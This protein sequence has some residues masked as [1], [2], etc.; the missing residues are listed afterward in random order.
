MIISDLNYLENTSE[1]V[2]GGATFTANKNVNIVVNVNEKIN[3]TK[4]ITSYV[5][6]TGNVA[7]AES[8]ATAFGNNTLAESFGF[9]N[10]D[11]YSSSS[12]AFAVAASS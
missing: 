11:P 2:I 12:N 5:S 3:I 8:G 9:A 7:T 1:E 4:N 10:A 6:L